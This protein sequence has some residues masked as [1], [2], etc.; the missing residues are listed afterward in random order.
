[1]KINTQNYGN[2]TV[3]EMHG[4]F[5]TEFAHT[6]SKKMTDLIDEGKDGIVLD[7]S[8]VGFLDSRALEALMDLR[9][10]SSSNACQLKIAGLDENCAKILEITRL[11]ENFDRYTELAEAVKSF[12]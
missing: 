6:F 12:A 7:F 3:A 10:Y 2:V 11:D 8:N 4:E 5:I 1:M 9:D